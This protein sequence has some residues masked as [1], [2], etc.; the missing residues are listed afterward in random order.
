MKK[1][2][3]SYGELNQQNLKTVIALSRATQGI[4]KRTSALVARSG[5]TISQFAVLEALYHKG[6]MNINEIIQ[7][8]LSTSGNMTVVISNLEK[9]DLITKCIH[10]QDKRSSLIAIT[11]QG[12]ERIEEIFPKHLKDL[13]E[14]FEVL[15]GEE[16]TILAEIL[17]KLSAKL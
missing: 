10:P 7:A 12:R 15:T 17:K 14:V 16:K 13:Q 8:V 5:L 9:Q 6:S 2:K 4:H 3:I 11:D 1:E